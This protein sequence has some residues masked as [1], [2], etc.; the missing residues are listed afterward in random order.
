MKPFNSLV[1]AFPECVST[2][3]RAEKIM[4]RR[5]SG[6]PIDLP[7]ELGYVCPVCEYEPVID[8]EFDERLHWSEYNGFM[9][10]QVCNKDYPSALCKPNIDEAIT[11][12]LNTVEGVAAMK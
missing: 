1:G 7:C 8:G 9:W 11:T 2:N 6:I 5:P 10:C 12:F 4:G 3:D